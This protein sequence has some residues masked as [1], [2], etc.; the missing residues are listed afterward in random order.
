VLKKLNTSVEQRSVK[1]WSSVGYRCMAGEL[2]ES[3]PG[4]WML[5]Y[6]AK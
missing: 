4:A 5:V 2:S 6:L 1:A 3:L